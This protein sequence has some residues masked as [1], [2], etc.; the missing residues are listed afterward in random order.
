MAKQKIIDR[1]LVSLLLVSIGFFFIFGAYYR[2]SVKPVLLISFI[3]F[4]MIGLKGKNLKISGFW[5]RYRSPEYF[6]FIFL[7][8]SVLISTF[9]SKDFMHSRHVI[10]ERY[11]PYFIVFEI[12]R[13]F[14]ASKTLSRALNESLG[15]NIFEFTKYLFIAAGLLMGIGGVVDY[16]RFHPERLFS[17]FGRIIDFYMLPLFIV[18]FLPVVFCF[19]FKGNAVVHRIT[20]T[21][22]LVML[23][24][25]MIFAGSRAAWIACS[26]GI[27][28]ALF[29]IGKKYLRYFILYLFI[30]ILAVY[31]IMPARMNNF[32]TY[33]FR[34]DIMQAAVDIFRDNLLF[35]AGPG[36]YEKL[37]YSYSK[38][39]VQIHVHCTYLE[40]LAELGIV[41][42]IAF[43]TIFISFYSRVFKN[44]STLN[45]SSHKFLYAGLLASNV[46]CLIFALF[47]SIITV[48]FHDAPIFW[49]MFGMAF[50]IESSQFEMAH[51]T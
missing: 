4:L 41:G 18:C 38:G 7:G 39:F 14:F 12:G 43:L 25:S 34:K 13:C 2:K 24:L 42:L 23:F 40:I 48:G 1:I 46:A 33:F 11:I 21:L 51:K 37:V 16:I 44:I 15:I 45:G 6:P 31:F 19:I 50:G 10:I 9:L 17:V 20:A 36:M 32:A 28:F 30:F 3:S 35:G 5:H 26:I 22:T 27:L 29:F 8:L 47:V 49:L